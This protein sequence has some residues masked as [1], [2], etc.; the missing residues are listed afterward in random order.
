MIINIMCS[1]MCI[2]MNLLLFFFHSGCSSECFSHS[3][4]FARCSLSISAVAC[5]SSLVP[6]QISTIKI[7]VVVCVFVH[8]AVLLCHLND[9][10]WLIILI[11]NVCEMHALARSSTHS[12]SVCKISVLCMD[13][14]KIWCL[15]S[16]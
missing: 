10:L 16:Q 6:L 1:F 15:R 8:V 2:R 3:S 12:A 11:L 14:I 4:T 5:F 13:S 7:G 9:R